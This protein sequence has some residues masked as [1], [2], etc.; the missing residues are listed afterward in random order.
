MR[1]ALPNSRSSL[2]WAGLTHW[3][4]YTSPCLASNDRQTSEKDKFMNSSTLLTLV[5]LLQSRLSRYRMLDLN[6][7]VLAL[8]IGWACHLV[9]YE[10]NS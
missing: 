3:H 10:Y 6:Q 2:A 4:L 7:L 8:A 9:F 1:K 5:S